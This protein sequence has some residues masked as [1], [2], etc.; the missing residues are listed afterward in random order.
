MKKRRSLT[1]HE[2]VHTLKGYLKDKRWTQA[3][4]VRF[5]D[6]QGITVT[7]QYLNDVLR[8]RRNPGPKFI[9]V[10]REITGVTLVDGL[11]EERSA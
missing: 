9:A 2:Q 6:E 10:F 7:T 1:K 4:F 8:G 5:L 11:V 3:E